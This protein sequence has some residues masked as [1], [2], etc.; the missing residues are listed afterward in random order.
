MENTRPLTA[1]ERSL[2]A[3]MFGAALDPGPVTIRHAKFWMFQPWWITM[4]PDGHIWCHPEGRSWS[5]CYAQEGLGLQAHFLHE[6]THVWQHQQG[7]NLILRRPP[8][9]RYR[10]TLAPGK[11]F[12]AYGL[13]QQACIVADAHLARQGRPAPATPAAYAALLP[14]G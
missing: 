1:P 3:T 2:A 13:E 9:A 11:P 5:P 12:T 8:F 7:I 6:L 10:Y 14:F 4:A